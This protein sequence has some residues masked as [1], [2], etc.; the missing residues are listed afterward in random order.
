MDPV[1][2]PN[3]AQRTYP[4][5]D[6]AEIARRSTDFVQAARAANTRRAY[7]S[8]W[9]HFTDWCRDHGLAD[10]PAAP[11]TVGM[12]VAAHADLL[13][14][15]TLTR[16]VSSIAVAHRMAG[17]QLDTRHPAIRDLMMGLRRSKGVAPRRAE[18]LTTPLVC[19]LLATC[20]DRLIDV[21]DRALLLVGFA[22]AFRRS[23]LTGLD[24]ADVAVSADGLRVT[25]RRSKSD[26][27]GEGQV[28][29]IGRTNSAT[30]PVGAYE[31]WVA[32]AGI[33]GGCVFRGINRHGHIAGTLSTNAVAG[34]V[35][36]R[37][38]LAGLDASVFSGHS[39]RAGF[40]TSAAAA[41]IEERVIMKQTRHRSV[42]VVRRY[43]RDGEV[44]ARNLAAEIGL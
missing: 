13:S 44:F 4:L 17:H 38:A 22:G 18:A 15:A 43:I 11:A 7:R 10:L 23:E 20:G 5:A 1:A 41:G 39:L 30:C 9:T 29:A 26:Q 36:R 3:S 40:A 33:A 42:A 12:Y 34:I 31:A 27:E 8:D 28:I 32:A 35:Q 25:I 14:V 16:R 19:K 37:A 21:R 24:L 2:A 6:L